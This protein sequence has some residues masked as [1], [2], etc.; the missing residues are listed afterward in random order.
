MKTIR[1]NP[2][3]FKIAL[4]FL[5]KGRFFYLQLIILAA[6]TWLLAPLRQ[7][8]A[9][10]IPPY[11]AYTPEPPDRQAS[12]LICPD[13][14]SPGTLA[15][16]RVVVY[17]PDRNTAIPGAQVH[18]S[19]RSTTQ[20][21]VIPLLSAETDAQGS[22]PIQFTVPADATGDYQLAFEI[23]S[24]IGEQRAT[25]PVR[26]AQNLRLDL[27]TDR[28]AY[29]PGQTIQ[30]H[31]LALEQTGGHLVSALPVRLEV[32][33]SRDN[34]IC[35]TSTHTSAYGVALAECVLGPTVNEGRYRVVAAAEELS[36][37]VEQ[38]VWVG[39]QG[40][41][42]QG[43][44]GQD[45]KRSAAE[46]GNRQAIL[47]SAVPESEMLEPGVE[48]LI[49][50]HTRYAD[51]TPVPCTLELIAP[52]GP[53]TL[54]TDAQG[55][56]V[57]RVTPSV[58]LS[59]TMSA[60]VTARD[61]R[62]Y[63]GRTN[64]S[65]PVEGGGR[66]FLVRPD[67]LT[68]RSGESMH[69]E[70]VASFPLRAV[71][72]DLI[73]NGQPVAALSSPAGDRAEF[74]IVLDPTWV[75]DLVL[76][77]YALNDQVIAD[78]RTVTVLPSAVPV[79]SVHADRPTY[80]VGEQARLAVYVQ[81]GQGKGVPAVLALAARESTGGSPTLEQ[82]VETTS[83]RLLPGV[84]A[85][86]R[87]IGAVAR[88]RDTPEEIRRQ[89]AQVDAAR[90]ARQAALGALM[91]RWLWGWVG[92]AAAGWLALLIGGW[93][94][95]WLRGRMF[96]SALLSSPFVLAL[97]IGIGPLIAYG[98]QQLWGPGA[99]I[100]LGLGWLGALLALLVYGWTYGDG[101]A[102]V[103][104]A[105]LIG[106]LALGRGIYVLTTQ[107]AAPLCGVSI[108]GP[109]VA[110]AGA[111]MAALIA[112]NLFAWGCRAAQRRSGALIAIALLALVTVSVAAGL[113]PAPTTIES[114]QEPPPP[115]PTALPTQVNV[116]TRTPFAALTARARTTSPSTIQPRFVDTLYW[117][118]GMLT[119][120][121]G[122]AEIAVPLPAE[123]IDWTVDLLAIT[124]EGQ[125]AL[126][127]LPL[128]SQDPLP[129]TVT[130]PPLL[131]VGDRV[132]VSVGLQ[133]TAQMTQTAGI[134]VSVPGWARPGWARPEWARVERR[135]EA[136][137]VEVGALG[138]V[139]LTVPLQVREGGTGQL[140]ITAMVGAEQKTL[141]RTVNVL[142]DG[143][144]V[145]RV[146]NRLTDETD[147]YKLRM[148]WSSLRGSDRIA[149]YVD[150]TWAGVL[151]RGLN[152]ALNHL[153]LG[154]WYAPHIVTP[155]DVTLPACYPHA[156]D[157]SALS[158]IVAEIDNV[159][160]LYDYLSRTGRLAPAL[161]ESIAR[162]ARDRYQYL[163]TFETP[164]GGFASFS[165]GTTATLADTAA[166]LHGMTQ[167]AVLTPVDPATSG[168][169]T[170]WLLERQASDGTWQPERLPPGWERFPRPEL[171]LTAQVAWALAEAGQPNAKAFDLLAKYPD[172]AQEPYSLA[173]IL[174]ALLAYQ[175]Q[176]GADLPIIAEVRARL[177]NMAQVQNGLALW[178]GAVSLPDGAV[179]ESADLERTSLALWALIRAG[180]EAPVLRQGILA[181]AQQRDAL[182]TWGSPTATAWALR[183]LNAAVQA[184]IADPAANEARVQA[185]TVSLANKEARKDTPAVTIPADGAS[186]MSY[187]FYIDAPPKGYN[188]V[189]L[190]VTGGPVL[191]QL[192]AEY[193]E[194][195][196]QVPPPSPE[197][198][199]VAM[200]LSYE[201]TT[202]RVGET[203]WVTVSVA[204]N[205]NG[206]A[207]LV[208][209]NLGL[210][211]GLG[212][213]VE[214]WAAMTPDPVADYR[215]S[216]RAIR[217]YL[218]DLAADR[219][220]TLAYRL[221]A[222]QP[223][224][225]RTLPTWAL[226]VA[227]PQQPTFREPTLIEV[228]P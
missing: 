126:A 158:Q 105:L 142:P 220:V 7:T 170:R 146:F 184:G 33:D 9:L 37:Y 54:T 80:Q 17:D 114:V 118:A 123:A 185:S 87:L 160:L 176:T 200:T 195:W 189:R 99:L 213:I 116:P 22:A 94:G 149:F 124:Q 190:L 155:T 89:F 139:T 223:S 14:L 207:R 211:P 152:A 128:H 52:G 67:R 46:M 186:D 40:T 103:L 20:S 177:I 1:L 221:R 117:Q 154:T 55:D 181:L 122:R 85:L 153:D 49:Y 27:T 24:W 11:P 228:K 44:S 187:V 219:S 141:T 23:D 48:N 161:R 97:A 2:K 175:A 225:A 171:A 212:P 215:L 216:D 197:E 174:H 178:R 102:Q 3:I 63:I 113:L 25:C 203:T 182:G 50:L 222:R 59:T 143:K 88:P 209:L 28:V 218:T 132:E 91:T 74:D 194:G 111:M 166:A 157:G 183:A 188:D 81:N 163:L 65:L 226:D 210:P 134:T 144:P 15:S 201:R 58:D 51:D 47:I 76:R 121:Q 98:G 151:T 108:S 66:G 205:R 167:L 196:A 34:R 137:Q 165:G 136:Q 191:Y 83:G 30:A 120:P 138:R 79:L 10:P 41:G 84:A 82:A 217:V 61:A 206:A 106:G 125:L 86:P 110:G 100:V 148:P 57:W 62:G 129:A 73:W 96:L 31:L 172:L 70:V 36:L 214:D 193:I 140:S 104:V 90:A 71:Y 147:T 109:L 32:Y 127:E 12:L 145:L 95:G 8:I 133:N 150:A 42:R 26:I 43:E 179:G 4:D 29:A 107:C 78:V 35:T 6:V 164:T 60:V 53:F 135:A 45:E 77:G 224:L 192:I 64:L 159:S 38:Q 208:E 169:V 92:L 69:V 16:A 56:A 19:L 68:Y 227:N 115:T 156:F 112:L 199:T 18:V 101:T 119:D 162:Y 168:R 204:L 131:T 180:S 93:R 130:L 198:E 75:G 39:R 72:L 202:L 173:M 5:W 13:T 21:I